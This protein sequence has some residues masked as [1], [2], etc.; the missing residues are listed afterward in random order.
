MSIETYDVYIG[1]VTE[2]D[3]IVWFLFF[4]LILIYI[5][6]CIN[7]NEQWFLFSKLH[8]QRNHQHIIFTLKD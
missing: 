6:S 5:C 1:N 4:L 8:A 3:T 2:K 7:C